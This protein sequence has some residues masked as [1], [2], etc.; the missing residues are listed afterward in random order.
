LLIAPEELVPDLERLATLMSQ[1][2]QRE[3]SWFDE[4]SA[5]RAELVAHSRALAQP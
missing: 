1:F 2:E 4:W 5:A 3:E